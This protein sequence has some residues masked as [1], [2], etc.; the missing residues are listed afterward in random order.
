[1]TFLKFISKRVKQF[2]SG[3][4]PS[5]PNET[6]SSGFENKERVIA[7]STALFFALCL[8]FI[9]NL[10]RDFTVT[11]DVP[12]QLSNLPDDLT[13]S[14]DIPEFARV[15]ITGEGWNLISVY[16]NPPRIMVNAEAEQVNLT[17]QIRNQVSAFTDLNIIQVQPSQLTIETERKASKKVPVLN[18][19]DISMRNQ[20]GLLGDPVLEPDSVVVTGAE[21]ILEELEAWET[22]DVEIRDVNQ[23]TE[24]EIQ[25]KSGSSGVSISPTSVM[26]KLNVAEFTEAEIRVP[27]R[28]RNLPSG[29]AVTYNPSSITV[30]FD[31][32]IDQYSDIQGTR[33][34]SAYVDYSVLEGDDSG[35]VTPQV[36]VSETN[37]QIVRLRSFQPPRV[38]YF[39]VVSQ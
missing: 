21:S 23:N 6:D 16:S 36:E 30:R 24:R 22:A 31:V 18:R 10:N 33:P 39:R 20:Y 3:D 1:M 7:F 19:V 25:L 14:S 12:I 35:R 29:Q 27:I 9:V 2:F 4:A 17:E 11:V 15:H 26:M 13:V 28:T 5:G 38:S 8:W 32:P 34:F 37:D